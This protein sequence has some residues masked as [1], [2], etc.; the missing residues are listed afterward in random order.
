M[1]LNLPRQM[2]WLL[3]A[4]SLLAVIVAIAVVNPR[5]MSYFGFNLMLGLG[6]PIALA[7]LAQMFV[8]VSGDLDLS[9]GAFI[10]FTACVAATWLNETP[11]LG[12]AVLVAGVVLYAAI[13]ALIA[14]RNLP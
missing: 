7:T 3:P 11:L 13:G 14:L 8:I 5:A 6:L 4:C 1:T 9:I 2:R 10:S 12:C